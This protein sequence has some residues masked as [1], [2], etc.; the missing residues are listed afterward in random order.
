MFPKKDREV[1]I[2]QDRAPSTVL[3]T[4]DGT[5][6]HSLT[7]SDSVV[8]PEHVPTPERYRWFPWGRRGE[9]TFPCPVSVEGRERKGPG[10]WPPPW[11]TGTSQEGE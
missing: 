6:T 10:S 11:S 9:T 7:Y 8:R 4:Y 2:V 3:G 5:F 1:W